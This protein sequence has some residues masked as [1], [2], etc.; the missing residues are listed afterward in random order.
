MVS[1]IRSSRLTNMSNDILPAGLPAKSSPPRRATNRFGGLDAHQFQR[2]MPA[3]P[4]P[5]KTRQFCGL[6]AV[7]YQLVMPAS[8]TPR[9]ATCVRFSGHVVVA[10]KKIE[11]EKKRSPFGRQRRRT[12]NYVDHHE[13]RYGERRGSRAAQA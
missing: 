4:C 1:L 11:Q 10:N 3:F 7:L 6:K 2:L 5:P 8:R 9:L 12:K 13:S